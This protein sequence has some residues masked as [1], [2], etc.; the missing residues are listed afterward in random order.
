MNNHFPTSHPEP[1]FDSSNSPV[2]KF[3]ESHESTLSLLQSIE[4]ALKFCR[5][6]LTAEQ[7][8]EHLPDAER[9]TESATRIATRESWLTHREREVLTLLLHGLSNRQISRD[10]N[11]SERTVKNHLHSIYGKLDAKSRT[12][13][14][15]KLSGVSD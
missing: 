7:Q 15:A 10:L 12:H 6:S 11:I 2:E 3:I 8:A 5:F 13:I 4:S 14:V 9:A 1:P